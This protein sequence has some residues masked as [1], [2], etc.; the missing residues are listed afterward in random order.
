MSTENNVNVIKNLSNYVKNRKDWR[1][2]FP[3]RQQLKF[4]Y[5]VEE[6]Y[7][8][9][10][11]LISQIITNSLARLSISKYAGC[12]AI[13]LDFSLYKEGNKYF[14]NKINFASKREPEKTAEI[15][16]SIVEY[17]F[18][19]DE[20][21]YIFEDLKN[22]IF[23]KFATINPTWQS[24]VGGQFAHRSLIFLTFYLCKNKF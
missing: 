5:N 21:N 19:D 10:F 15:M 6:K 3:I 2:K 8:P 1:W 11:Y 24:K 13:N 16:H 20:K 12:V 18:G 9:E 17:C 14:L 4:V 7:E 22:D 23:S